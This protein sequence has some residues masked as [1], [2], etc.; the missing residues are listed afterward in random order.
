MWW[1]PT[2]APSPWRVRS[3]WAPRFTSASL[4]TPPGPASPSISAP[5]DG[6]LLLVKRRLGTPVKICHDMVLRQSA[7]RF[8]DGHFIDRWQ[9]Q[10]DKLSSHQL[11]FPE[12]ESLWLTN[13]N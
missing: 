10:H 3:A 13:R 11:L 7:S 12:L 1:R 5:A 4:L 8:D 2:K 9:G 6:R